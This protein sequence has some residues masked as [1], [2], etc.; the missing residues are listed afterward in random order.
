MINTNG[1]PVDLRPA[2]VTLLGGEMQLWSDAGAGGLTV[3][4]RV[5]EDLMAR[6]AKRGGRPANALLVGSCVSDGT[7]CACP[8]M[9]ST[10]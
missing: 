1:L 2:G 3:S 9:R 10:T 7:C 6:L 4:G 8:R 5:A